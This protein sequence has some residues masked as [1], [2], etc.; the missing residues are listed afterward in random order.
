MT[1]QTVEE[2]HQVTGWTSG[3]HHDAA[4]EEERDSQHFEAI[5]AREHHLWDSV[6]RYAHIKQS[7]EAGSS[8]HRNENGTSGQQEKDDD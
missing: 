3:G 4:K 5:D 8:S 1:D 2:V 6:Q 7:Q